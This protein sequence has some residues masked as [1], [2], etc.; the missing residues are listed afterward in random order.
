MKSKRSPTRI[1]NI[2]QSLRG[3]TLLD[4]ISEYIKLLG[5][6]RIVFKS[7]HQFCTD[8]FLITLVA[9]IVCQ[10]GNYTFDGLSFSDTSAS[11]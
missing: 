3:D 8:F 10:A 6:M 5:M 4:K 7:H 11:K 1:I 2:D 9:V